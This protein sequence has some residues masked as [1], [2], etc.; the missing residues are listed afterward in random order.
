QSWGIRSR[1]ELID[2]LHWIHYG[3]HRRWFEELGRMLAGLS[4]AQGRGLEPERREQP[5]LEHRLLMVDVYYRSLGAK[6]LVG[7]GLFP[8][9]RAVPV[10]LCDGVP[11]RGRGVEPY[12]SRGPAAPGHVLLLEGA[13]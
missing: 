1:E 2:S 5:L 12:H 11:E 6:S 13:G 7:M 3:G 10:G 4:P 8:L 9:R